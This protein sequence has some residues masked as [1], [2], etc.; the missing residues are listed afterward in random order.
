MAGLT[1][2]AELSRDVAPESATTS[3]PIRLANHP[4][5]PDDMPQTRLRTE[6]KPPN[7][8]ATSSD[9]EGED[10][11]TDYPSFAP[12]TVPQ[13]PDP[14][15]LPPNPSLAPYLTPAP[16]QQPQPAGALPRRGLKDFEPHPTTLQ[17]ST[18][19][20]SRAAMHAA[21]SHTRTHA[22]RTRVLGIYDER[23][24]TVRVRKRRGAMFASVGRD[25][26]KEDGREWS[27]GVELVA[28]EAL[29]G[30]ESG[31]VDLRYRRECFGEEKSEE[32]QN[33]EDDG[34]VGRQ[35]AAVDVNDDRTNAKDGA[36]FDPEQA[37]GDESTLLPMSLQGAYA[38]FL[39][40]EAQRTDGHGLTVEKYI[41]YASLKRAGFI[42]TRAEGF[43]GRKIVKRSDV[44][45]H[46][47]A[48]MKRTPILTSSSG[49]SN[50]HEGRLGL[51]ARLYDLLF[52]P[53]QSKA[54]Q[55]QQQQI[56][57]RQASGPLVRPGLY[58][59]YADIYRLLALVPA[60]APAHT[61]PAPHESES[62]SHDCTP[63]N[64]DNND[65]NNE[66]DTI[67]TPFTTTY[68]IYNP[69][70]H[71]RK[72][73]P[74]FPP[75]HRICVVSARETRLPTL[76]ELHALLAEQPPH[77]QHQGQQQQQQACA[78]KAPCQVDSRT[79]VPDT[80][81]S[82]QSTTQINEKTRAQAT[83]K[84]KERSQRSIGATYAALKKGQCSVLLA[85][86][87]EG[88]VSY[89]RVSE[90]GFV[91]EGRLGEREAGASGGGKGGGRGR[92][93]ARGRGGRG[94]RGGGR[95][96]GG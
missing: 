83:Q 85:V 52:N 89:L 45:S 27:G 14:I 33:R 79:T 48:M 70:T 90:A 93:G 46:H 38:A 37:D 4:T 36:S 80:T 41:V 35:G 88:V 42:V 58:R 82:P 16:Q 7:P 50:R 78:D 6:H 96:G 63:I 29:W 61:Y 30:L 24:G 13:L 11:A 15:T 95:G 55:R 87:D 51:F 75:H 44:T 39:G 73:A 19:A 66:N 1:E 32:D 8:L 92:G 26:G 94:G 31:R 18:L 59:N 21:L 68:N 28:E 77:Q 3:L 65:N 17:A 47:K 22:A 9:D 43:S 34:G 23:T 64:N 81:S 74:P 86:V 72:S 62:A 67:Q 69:A 57:S 10:I 56:L 40:D 12:S 53:F 2:E 54:Q 5:H 91:V 84:A 71:Y 20:T 25:L 60:P 49:A 76:P